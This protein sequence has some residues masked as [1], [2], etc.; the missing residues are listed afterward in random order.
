MGESY[1]YIYI[2]IY[3]CV[4]IGCPPPL[5]LARVTP[6]PPLWV[7]GFEGGY[8]SPVGASQSGRDKVR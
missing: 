3:I 7:L 2:Y 4:R 6:P 1:S 5:P 8:P